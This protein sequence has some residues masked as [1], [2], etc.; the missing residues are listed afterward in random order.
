MIRNLLGSLRSRGRSAP[1]P[2]PVLRHQPIFQ[3]SNC[4]DP[5]LLH[6]E[7][8]ANQLGQLGILPFTERP[9]RALL[10]GDVAIWI[11]EDGALHRV[12]FVPGTNSK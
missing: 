4:V 10:R 6:H 9:E 7:Y 5:P 3:T 2:G 11:G 12:P 8:E 1:E